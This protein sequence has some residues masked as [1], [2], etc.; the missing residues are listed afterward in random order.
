M[1][2]I[3][4]GKRERER[5]MDHGED[6]GFLGSVCDDTQLCK[7]DT[8]TLDDKVDGAFF[9]PGAHERVRCLSTLS[10]RVINTE[11]L[12]MKTNVFFPS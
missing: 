9:P 2:I 12:I 3:I 7:C 4:G 1:S 5:W 6:R 11:I 8:F 10:S